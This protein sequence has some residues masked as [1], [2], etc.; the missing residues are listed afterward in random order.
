MTSRIDR[1]L[2]EWTEVR[3]WCQHPFLRWLHCTL[4]KGAKEPSAAIRRVTARIELHDESCRHKNK[5]EFES[6]SG[7]HS[8]VSFV[9]HSWQINFNVTYK[10]IQRRRS[11]G[12]G[13][14]TP[15]PK[16]KTISSKNKIK[17]PIEVSTW[18]V[19]AFQPDPTPPPPPPT[20]LAQLNF[21]S[22]IRS[23]IACLLSTSSTS[24]QNK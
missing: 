21:R 22:A 24:I 11:W 7:T 3:R 23:L 18:L 8:S 19:P 17:T 13:V 5:Q 2:P 15:P 14:Q 16:K 4:M 6:S 10:T 12:G 20:H 9:P 1:Q